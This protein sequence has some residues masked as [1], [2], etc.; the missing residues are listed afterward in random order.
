MQTKNKKYKIL[1]AGHP[2]PNKQS[3]HATKKIINFLKKRG[4]KDYII[5]LISG[6]SSSLVS[7][8]DGITLEDK[9]I[10]TKLLLKSGANIHE[11]NLRGPDGFQR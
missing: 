10:V 3:I 1:H 7:L 6:G 8:P 11:I 4:R 9:K 2:I 5:F